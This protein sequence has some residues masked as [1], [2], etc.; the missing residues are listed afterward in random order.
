MERKDLNRRDFARLTAAAFGGMIAGTTVGCGD[1]EKK[2]KESPA[3]KT[4]KESAPPPASS[5]S[6]KKARP[7]GY[8]NPKRNGDDHKGAEE[9]QKSIKAGEGDYV[10]LSGKNVCRGLNVCKQHKGGDNSCAGRG[11]C[12]VAKAHSCHAENECKGQGGCGK[13]PGINACKGKGECAVP[14]SDDAWK[15]ARAKF[16]QVTASAGRPIGDAPPKKK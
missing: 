11:D 9:L 14:L 8:V 10:M 13:T 2:E 16:E 5:D 3:G 15:K 12:A 4:S 1:A 6:P 7:P